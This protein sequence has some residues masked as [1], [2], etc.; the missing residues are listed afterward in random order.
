MDNSRIVS[1]GK[2]RNFYAKLCKCDCW[3]VKVSFL[4]YVISD[5]SMVMDPSEVDAVPQREAL[6]L[7]NENRNFLDFSWLLPEIMEGFSKLAFSSLQ[8]TCKG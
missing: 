6:E 4:G 7:V 8:L 3:L 5:E 2:G 1:N